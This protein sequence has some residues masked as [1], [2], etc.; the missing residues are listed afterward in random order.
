MKTCIAYCRV[1]TIMQEEKESLDTQM[2]GV[3]NFCKKNNLKLIQIFSDVSSGGNRNRKGFIEAQRYI[4]NYPIDYFVSYDVSRIARDTFAFLKIF[5]QLSEKNVKLKLINQPSLDAD[6]AM[7]KM[8]LT[9]MAAIFEFFK[10]DSAERVKDN[11]AVKVNQGKRMG[12]KAPYGYYIENGK[13]I[14]KEEE[15]IIIKKIFDNFIKGKGIAELG[16]EMG[17]SPTLVSIRLDNPTYAGLNRFGVRRTDKSLM[18]QFKNPEEKVIL[19]KGDWEP[20]VPLEVF[21]QVKKIKNNYRELNIRNSNTDA[22]YLLSGLLRCECGGSS[23]GSISGGKRKYYRCGRCGKGFRTEIVEKVILDQLCSTDMLDSLNE[24]IA[25]NKNSVKKITKIKNTKS[26]ID[27]EL[28]KARDLLIKEIIS[29]TEYLEI[30]REK[31]LILNEIAKQEIEFET[32]EE[33]EISKD[34]I[35]I[36]KETLKNINIEDR[37]E[38]RAIL[39]QL[40]EKIIIK[41]YDDIEIYLHI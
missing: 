11:M 24:Q 31:T 26:L 1:S 13:L 6:S 33:K 18:K 21:E 14:I 39:K 10:F 20:I 5:Q 12:G 4:E 32:F 17:W 41:S 15:A 27:A 22:K 30:K 2:E 25:S 29:E 37:P 23:G 3:H 35:E 16:R 38:T 36:F 19:S 40:I 8:I 28:K 7:G 9:V 34:F